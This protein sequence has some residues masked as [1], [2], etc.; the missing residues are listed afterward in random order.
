MH[1]L[2]RHIEV[3]SL[4]LSPL[5]IKVTC[6][7]EIDAYHLL[8]LFFSQSCKKCRPCQYQSKYFDPHGTVESFF[9]DDFL[10]SSSGMDGSTGYDESE[11]TADFHSTMSSLDAKRIEDDTYCSPNST[12]VWC[13]PRDYN[14]EKH[15]FTCKPRI[16]FFTINGHNLPCHL[17]WQIMSYFCKMQPIAYLLID[18]M[19]SSCSFA[20]DQSFVAMELRFQIR[21]GRNQQH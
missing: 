15:P 2:K 11:Y 5:G 8:D 7:A 9:Q 19:I 6:T 16:N 1:F 18:L 14:R 12:Y 20:H 4:G 17:V 21:G 13:L 3:I 10:L